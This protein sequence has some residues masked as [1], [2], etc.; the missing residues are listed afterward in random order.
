MTTN[1][2][3]EPLPCPF[4]EDKIVISLQTGE[5]MHPENDCLFEGV[6]FMNVEAWNTRSA[7][8]DEIKELREA[9][10]GALRLKEL[11][12]YTYPVDSENK[13]EAIALQSMCR[14]FEQALNTRKEKL[15]HL[16]D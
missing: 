12:L 14:S 7:Q 8:A 9:L 15:T 4:C 2:K 5:Y 13:G 3:P 11:W 6:K 16:K 1:D 10:E